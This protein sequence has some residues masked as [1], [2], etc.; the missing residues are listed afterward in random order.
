[1]IQKILSPYKN[2]SKEIW[3]LAVITLINR[4]GAMVIPFL[5]LYL[6]KSLNFTLIEVGSIMSFY[7]FGSFFG[8]WIGG[9]LTDLF[10]Y[11]KVMYT[12]LFLGGIL[13][14]L[15]QYL[16][17]FWDFGFGIFILIFVVDLF[18]PAMWVAIQDYSSDETKTRSVT[19]IRLSIN[20]GFSF[21]PALAGLII[22]T[23]GYKGL[24]WIDGFTTFTAGILLYHYLFQKSILT[25]T[26]KEIAK[27]TSPYKDTPFLIF[28]FAMFLMAVSFVQFIETLPLFYNDVIHLDEQS[29][30]YLLA[31]NGGLI[32]LIEMPIV[33]YL[34]KKHNQIKLVIVGLVLFA[35]SF[36]VLNT[37]H[38]TLIAVIG[39]LLLTF[40]EIFS[41]PFSNTFAME[42]SKKGNQGSYMALYG[43]TFSAAFII[44]PKMGMY[45]LDRYGYTTLW[46]LVTIILILSILIML[47]LRRAMDKE[48]N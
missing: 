34:E 12:S 11:Y 42:R 15:L 32:F 29:I 39:M 26:K 20:L 16:E 37:F 24:F 7:G 31:L 22:A 18:R 10:G 17:T 33:E 44:S 25:K 45:V 19:L 14:V 9:K 27:L 38:S 21:G 40:G 48:K 36:I 5:S 46:N 30:G 6:T 1:M 43:M 35:L 8:T 41:F 3:L 4:T 23:I 28:W 2:L 47:L 13:F